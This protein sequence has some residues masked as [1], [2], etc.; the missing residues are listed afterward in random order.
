[1]SKI[2][3]IRYTK[4]G[5][6]PRTALA[7]LKQARQFL[8]E[9][10][11]KHWVKG[12]EYRRKGKALNPSDPLCGNWGVCAVGAVALVTGDLGYKNYPDNARIIYDGKGMASPAYEGAVELLNSAAESDP[13]FR[14]RHGYSPGGIVELNDAPNVKRATVIKQFDRAIELAEQQARQRMGRRKGFLDARKA[15]SF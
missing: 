10:G 15:F 3:T 5:R 11:Q 14:K 13:T 6:K 4:F 8:V 1:M 12:S 2:R 9:E 7:A